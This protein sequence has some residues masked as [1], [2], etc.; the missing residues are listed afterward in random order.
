MNICWNLHIKAKRHIERGKTAKKKP[1]TSSKTKVSLPLH[2]AF[3]LPLGFFRFDFFRLWRWRGN[4]FG[5]IFDAK[6]GIL[7]SAHLAIPSLYRTRFVLTNSNAV[8]VEPLVTT[9]APC[10]EI[11]VE[12]LLSLESTLGLPILIPRPPNQGHRAHQSS[13]VQSSPAICSPIIKRLI[14]GFL[15]MQYSSFPPTK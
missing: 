3:R 5:F 11:S 2:P 1:A 9:I 12:L 10:Q 6:F 7:R 13:D 8:T 14:S 4:L 15:Q